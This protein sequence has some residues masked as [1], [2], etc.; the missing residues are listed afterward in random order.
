MAHDA[1]LREKAIQLRTQHN[2]TLDAICERLALPKTTVY[3]WIK[4]LPIDRTEKQSLAQRHGTASM[5]AKYA[6]QREA[7]YQQG[8]TD[9]PMLM[10]DLTFRDFVVLYMAEGYKKDRNVIE[11][12]NSDAKLVKLAHRW[13]NTFRDSTKPIYYRMQ[14]H[15]DHDEAELKAYWA[16][17]IGIQAEAISILRKSNSGMLSGRQFRSPYGLLSVRISDTYFRAKLEAWMDFIKAQW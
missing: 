15:V 3:G 6:A 1:H 4:D 8:L 7:A 5:Q 12:V 16:E 17:M 10:Q 13:I 11:F 2:M 14:C 9:A